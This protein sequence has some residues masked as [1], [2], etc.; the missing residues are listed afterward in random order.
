MENSY[1]V[2]ANGNPSLVNIPPLCPFLPL[3]WTGNVG[4]YRDHLGVVMD[5][6][7]IHVR[8]EHDAPSL[9]AIQEGAACKFARNNDPLRGGFRVQ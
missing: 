3:P 6:G 7:F 8:F 9:F 5:A 4:A 2:A 1:W